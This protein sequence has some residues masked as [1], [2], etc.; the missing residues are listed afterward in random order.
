VVSASESHEERIERTPAHRAGLNA[1][2]NLNLMRRELKEI[3]RRI[4]R[5]GDPRESHEERI[6]RSRCSPAGR[7]GRS[8]R[9]S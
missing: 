5:R 4:I 3:L 8:S 1:L 9:I 6:E 7:L 2:M